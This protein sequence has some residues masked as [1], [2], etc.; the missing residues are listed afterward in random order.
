[1]P[2]TISTDER[3]TRECYW[4]LV[5]DGVISPDDRV[6]LLD[7]VIV[8]MAPQNPPHAFVMTTLNRLLAAASSGS[9]L[10]RV[11][12]PL[13]IGRFSTPEPDFAIVAGRAEDYL[14]AHPTTALL[15]IEVA[16][17]TLA[18]DRLTKTRMYAA[19]GIPEYW[20]VNLRDP[21]VEVYTAPVPAER[22]YA[23]R[24]IVRAGERLAAESVP[25]VAIS[26]ADI[27]PP[28]VVIPR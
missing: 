1:M 8:S 17:S 5:A 14:T 22:R 9:L 12:L 27:L 24:R 18:Q 3:I 25:G 10:L 28:D 19:G 16:D 23:E 6:E 13:D 2:A 7:G 21:S 4:Q 15:V 20:I 11:A 26:V